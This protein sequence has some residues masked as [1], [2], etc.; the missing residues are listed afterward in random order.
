MYLHF[1]RM[2]IKSETYLKIDK[3]WLFFFFFYCSAA[4]M[5]LCK[6]QYLALQAEVLHKWLVFISPKLIVSKS[7]YLLSKMTYLCVYFFPSLWNTDHY[8]DWCAENC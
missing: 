6:R 5:K 8:T 1:E 7:F 2:H 4:E 3:N